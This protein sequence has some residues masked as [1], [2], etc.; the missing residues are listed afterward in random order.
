MKMKHIYDQEF[1]PFLFKV[2]GETSYELKGYSLF[3]V[4]NVRKRILRGSVYETS[5]KFVFHFRI[6]FLL[7]SYREKYLFQNLPFL[8]SNFTFCCQFFVEMPLL[9][10]ISRNCTHS[11][12]YFTIGISC[13]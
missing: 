1:R 10:S 11:Y 4:C 2:T 9:Q 8:V 13:S 6:F 12:V 7:T 3:G 5:R